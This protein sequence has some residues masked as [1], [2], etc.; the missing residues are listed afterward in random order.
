M[1]EIIRS[2]L[3]PRC[4]QVGGFIDCFENLQPWRERLSEKSVE[5]FVCLLF[6]VIIFNF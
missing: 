1:E 3:T 5:S 6:D 4:T 2:N